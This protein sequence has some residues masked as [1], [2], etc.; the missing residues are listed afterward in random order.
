MTITV[1]NTEI[2]NTFDYWRVRTNEVAHAMSV[3]AVT[4][5]GNP[6]SGDAVITGKF[7]ANSINIA[8]SSSGINITIPTT[9]Q[10]ANGQYFLNA[11]GA[12]AIASIYNNTITTSGLSAQEIDNYAMADYNGAE[13]LVHI[14]N[15]DSGANGFTITKLLTYHD[16]GFGYATEYA[17]MNSNSVGGTISSLGTFTADANSTHVRVFI[18]PYPSAARVKYTRIVV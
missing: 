16:T 12:W 10:V 3:N 7:S 5:G 14:K 11:N 17:I 18:T 15:M 1:A 6:A 9:I 13:Y 4:V 8:N 2:S